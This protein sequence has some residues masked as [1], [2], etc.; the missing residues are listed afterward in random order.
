[1]LENQRHEEEYMQSD[2]DRVLRSI[3]LDTAVIDRPVSIPSRDY[4]LRKPLRHE[5][6][7][8]YGEH[9]SLPL[10]GSPERGERSQPRQT[11]FRPK[12]EAYFVSVGAAADFPAT[13]SRDIAADAKGE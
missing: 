9:F 13:N 6:R 12:N 2:H 10:P 1:M 7:Y 8:Q 11:V 4:Q 3:C 5:E